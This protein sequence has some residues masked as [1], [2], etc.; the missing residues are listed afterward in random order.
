MTKYL[1]FESSQ[2]LFNQGVRLVTEHAWAEIN[3]GKLINCVKRDSVATRSLLCP[4]PDLV[5][6][7]AVLPDSFKHDPLTQLPE[8]VFFPRLDRKQYTYTFRLTKRDGILSVVYKADE[9]GN[10]QPPIEGEAVEACGVLLLTLLK[11]RILTARE[12]NQLH[13]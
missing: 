11:H 3:P 13:Y 1:S 5:E 2:A 6:L 9:W 8:G 4:A 12:L 10:W 7:L